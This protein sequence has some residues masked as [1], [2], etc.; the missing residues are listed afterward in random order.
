MKRWRCTVCGYIHT[1]DEPPEQCPNCGAPK[2]KFVEIADEESDAGGSSYTGVLGWLTRQRGHAIAVHIPNGVLPVATIFLLLAAVFQV[3]ELRAA[4]YYN[5]LAVLVGMPL[6]LFTGYLDWQQHF[7]GKLT[8]I[9]ATKMVCGVVV[10]LLALVL[11]TWWIVDSAA[12]RENAT[13]SGLF[14]VLHLVALAAAVLA[15]FLGGKLVFGRRE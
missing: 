5:M 1:G 3:R 4:A 13:L 9:I 11:V 15:G 6:V 14:L 2:E 10:L 12:I 8:K 7:G